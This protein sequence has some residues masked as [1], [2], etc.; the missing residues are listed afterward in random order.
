MSRELWLAVIFVGLVGFD[1]VY[2]GWLP[3]WISAVTAFLFIMSQAFIVY[4][5][6]AIRAWNVWPIVPLFILTG[7][8]SG[9]GLFLLLEWEGDMGSTVLLLG[10]ATWLMCLGTLLHY[11]FGFAL[12]DTDFRAATRPLRT[13]GALVVG[14][15]VGLVL[16]FALLAMVTGGLMGSYAGAAIT[17]AG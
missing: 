1:L 9:F 8:S 10:G 14:T 7:L 16:P 6:R 2:P 15:G 3:L 5:S 17:L 11:L 12:Q 4:K 13:P